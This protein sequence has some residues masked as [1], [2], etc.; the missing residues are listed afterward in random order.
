[1]KVVLRCFK[2]VSGLK[3][4]FH[5]SNLIGINVEKKFLVADANILYC[6]VGNVPFKFLGLPIGANPMKI[7]TWQPVIDFMKNRLSG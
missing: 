3:I 4:I 2:L 7:G 1:M 6:N 5:E